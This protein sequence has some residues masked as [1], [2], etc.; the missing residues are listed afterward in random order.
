MITLL[1][2]GQ[3]EIWWSSWLT[4]A[5]EKS[6]SALSATKRDLAEFVSV[7]GNDT[8]TAV[9]GAS[10]NIT[11]ILH[12]SASPE[13]STDNNSKQQR[14]PPVVD[15]PAQ[16]PY[17]RCQAELF[18]V[19]NNM[20]TYLQEPSSEGRVYILEGREGLEQ[21]L[22]IFILY[23]PPVMSCDTHHHMMMVCHISTWFVYT[24]S[25]PVA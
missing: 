24:D 20:D 23:P 5:K 17:D 16:A 4:S 2:S 9:E 1:F 15:V 14:V 6:M 13:E 12:S 11:K 7:L 22:C 3:N 10:V 19:Q 25:I 18:A 8:K 21:G